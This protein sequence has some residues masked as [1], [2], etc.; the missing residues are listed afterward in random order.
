MSVSAA[1]KEKQPNNSQ[2]ASAVEKPKLH[3]RGHK[4]KEIHTRLAKATAQDRN[5]TQNSGPYWK[6]NQTTIACHH[7]EKTKRR[8]A[9]HFGT[10]TQRHRARPNMVSNPKNTKRGQ[11]LPETQKQRAGQTWTANQ[12]RQ[13]SQ[14]RIPNSKQVA[15]HE[16]TKTKTQSAG[17][18]D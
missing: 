8:Q 10:E 16:L 12:P 3:Q 4:M 1:G 2:R 6:E 11:H 13:A 18:N 15:G 7:P 14:Y 9:G 17:H 5:P